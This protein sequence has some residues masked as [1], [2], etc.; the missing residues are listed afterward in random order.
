MS[1]RNRFLLNNVYF[2]NKNTVFL[3]PSFDAEQQLASEWERRHQEQ[4]L[5]Y[6]NVTP[7]LATGVAALAEA[8][9]SLP[10]AVVI[11][12]A[13]MGIPVGDPRLD[14]LQIRDVVAF[15]RSLADPPYVCP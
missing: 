7:R 3:Q 5:A 2:S 4:A 15:V 9:P 12:A 14:D 1:L 10:Q 13:Q 11:G 8:Y 6:S